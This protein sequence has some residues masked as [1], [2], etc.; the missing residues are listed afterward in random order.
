MELLDLK[1]FQAR[2]KAKTT[3]V[4]RDIGFAADFA[5]ATAPGAAIASPSAFIILTGAEPLEIQE[6]SGPLR[7]L[8]DVTVSVLLALK[9]AGVRGSAGLEQL[10]APAAATRGA[11]FGWAHPDAERKCWSGGESIEDFDSKTGVLVYRLDFVARAK[12]QE[13]FE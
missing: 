2:L 1:P 11:L 4:I 13:T 10:A 3:G 7:Q 8:F 6:G 5:A 9:L 12:I